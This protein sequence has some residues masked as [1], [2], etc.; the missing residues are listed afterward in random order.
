MAEKV[1]YSTV[2]PSSAEH[3]NDEVEARMHTARLKGEIHTNETDKAAEVSA[4]T[5]RTKFDGVLLT[6]RLRKS[7]FEVTQAIERNLQCFHTSH[8]DGI[9]N[10]NS[11]CFAALRRARLITGQRVMQC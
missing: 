3:L 10:S 8:T 5:T 4:Q 1:A 6:T 2:T 11:T 7:F 9:R